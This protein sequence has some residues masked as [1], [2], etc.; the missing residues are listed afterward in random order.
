M[1]KLKTK[2]GV[3][4]RFRMTKKGKI[5]MPKCCKGHILTKKS[6]ARKRKLKGSGYVGKAEARHIRRLMPYA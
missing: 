5:K 3:A 6:R 1:P 4:K 2:K